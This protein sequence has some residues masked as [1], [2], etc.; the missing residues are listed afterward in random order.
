MCRGKLGED[1]LSYQSV[2]T[3]LDYGIFDLPEGRGADGSQ[4]FIM[5]LHRWDTSRFSVLD[6]VCATLFV[7]E[8][9][10][11]KYEELE[12]HGFRLLADFAD[13]TFIQ[14]LKTQAMLLGGG[15]S[16]LIEVVEVSSVSKYKVRLFQPLP[17]I[18]QKYYTYTLETY[19][20]PINILL[21][22]VVFDKSDIIMSDVSS[23]DLIWS[24]E[25]CHITL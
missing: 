13:Y 1:Q 23:C 25:T 24:V 8:T 15:R 18:Q 22:I 14:Q 20:A 12:I 17:L 19:Y 4:G 16:L 9:L 3:V 11:D 6:L 21:T 2:K 10:L 7:L 5:Y